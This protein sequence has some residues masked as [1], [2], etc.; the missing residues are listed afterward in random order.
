MH[1]DSHGHFHTN[2]SVWGICKELFLKYGFKSTRLSRNLIDNDNTLKRIYKTRY[3]A[4]VKRRFEYTTD[5][6]GQFRDY[7]AVS[8]TGR[9]HTLSLHDKCIELMCHPVYNNGMLENAGSLFFEDMLN[10][11]SEIKLISY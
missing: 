9:L 10:E 1:V 2:Y 5:Y 6:F 7:K 3:N 4:D 11:F 8:E